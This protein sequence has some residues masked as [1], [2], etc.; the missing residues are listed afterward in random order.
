MN[1]NM[2]QADTMEGRGRVVRCEPAPAVTVV[3]S[4]EALLMRGLDSL[5]KYTTACCDS[6]A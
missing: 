5:L 3:S 4:D 6:A 1:G 2:P